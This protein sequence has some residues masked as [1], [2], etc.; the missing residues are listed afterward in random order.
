VTTGEG[1]ATLGVTP[2]DDFADLSRSTLAA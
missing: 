1:T 2:L